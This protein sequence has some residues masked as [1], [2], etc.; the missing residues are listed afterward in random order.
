VLE[1]GSRGDGFDF[2]QTLL[3]YHDHTATLRALAS[4]H[5]LPWPE[6]EEAASSDIL[7]RAAQF[8]ASRLTAPV[9]RYLADRGFPEAFVRKRRIGYAPVSPSWRDILVRHIPPRGR[10]LTFGNKMYPWVSLA[11]K[12]RVLAVLSCTTI[13]GP[14]DLKFHCAHTAGA[15]C[16]DLIGSL[17]G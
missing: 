13:P 4:E 9:I 15:S 12:S 7:D 14:R 17:E 6:H 3:D 11:K 1:C 10:G 16:L 2:P 8:Y 5:H